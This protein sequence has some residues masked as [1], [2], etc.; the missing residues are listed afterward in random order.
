M[1]TNKFW[2]NKL[3]RWLISGVIFCAIWIIFKDN[4][5]TRIARKKQ[6]EGRDEIIRLDVDG[7]ITSKYRDKRNLRHFRYL[8]GGDTVDSDIFVVEGS[9]FYNYLKE[10]DSI[11]KESG[12]LLFKVTRFGHDTVHTLRY[13]CD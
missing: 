10:G 1:G 9:D 13:G 8:A 2:E 6:C 3:L 4:L 12:T 7:I 5:S 11:K